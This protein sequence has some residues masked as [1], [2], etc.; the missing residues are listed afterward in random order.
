MREIGHFIGG[1]PVSGSSGAFGDVFNPAAGEISARVALA[2]R[3]EVDKAVAAVKADQA[4]ALGM[5]N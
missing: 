4:V 5:F 2:S 1:K 3:A